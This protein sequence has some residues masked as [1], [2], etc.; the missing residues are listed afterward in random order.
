MFNARKILEGESTASRRNEPCCGGLEK[1]GFQWNIRKKRRSYYLR[2]GKS[3]AEGHTTKKGCFKN[4]SVKK[5]KTRASA[6]RRK[7]ELV[8]EK[9]SD[10]EGNIIFL[11]G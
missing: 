7:A 6:N 10:L 3:G 5:K 1:L 8:R 9:G 2:E 11:V 4:I